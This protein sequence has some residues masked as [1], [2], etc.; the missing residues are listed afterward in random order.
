MPRRAAVLLCLAVLLACWPAP[1]SAQYFGRNKVQYRTFDFRILKTAH[2]DV[3]YYPEEADA[4]RIVGRLAERW[5]ARLNAF[6]E[7]ELTGRQTIILYA[8][9]AQIGRA[10]V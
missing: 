6:F 8:T 3:Y 9:A 7:H 10:H 1:A 4:A 2:F 5:R